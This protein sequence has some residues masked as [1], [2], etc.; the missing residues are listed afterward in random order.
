MSAKFASRLLAEGLGT[1]GFLFIAFSGIAASVDLP[2]SIGSAGIA[3]GFGLGL[4]L[5]IFAFGHISGGHFNPAVTLG[6]VFGGRFPLRELPAYW[7]AQIIGAFAAAAAAIGVYSDDVETAFVNSTSASDGSAF[8]LEVI[9]TAFFLIVISAVATD[10]RAPWYG[11]MAPVAIG[12][13]I[14]TALLVI[15]PTSGGSFNPARSI[16]PAVLAA[17]GSQ[18]WIYVVGP[19]LGGALGGAAYWGIRSMSGDDGSG[20]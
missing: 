5:M 8:I 3:A 17:E 15:G 7:A 10:T 6:L 1:F 13:F 19:L 11:V 12:G 14:F 2:G 4:G 16:A 9:G 18:L 20:G